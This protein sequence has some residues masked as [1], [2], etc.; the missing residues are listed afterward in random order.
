[1]DID[2]KKPLERKYNIKEIE[3]E[4]DNKENE[5]KTLTLDKKGKMKSGSTTRDMK[6]GAEKK[7]GGVRERISLMERKSRNTV[8]RD[9]SDGRINSI[10]KEK[11]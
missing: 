1:M 4:T 7:E 2:R 9:G 10:W 6:E 5:K 8:E 11:D 3:K